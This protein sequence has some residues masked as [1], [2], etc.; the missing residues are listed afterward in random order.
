MSAG[1]ETG[2][3]IG[4]EY[5]MKDNSKLGTGIINMIFVLVL[6]IT[7]LF[8]PALTLKTQAGEGYHIYI[9][10]IA[11]VVTVY[12]DGE[13]V[14]AMITSTGTATPLSGT[15]N[16][17]N[18]F[19]W[20][21]LNGNVYGQYCTR[22]YK[23]ILFQSVPYTAYYNYGSLKHGQFDLLGTPASMGCMRLCVGDAKWI[24]DNIPAN[25]PV[26]FYSDEEVPSPMGMPFSC[27][28]DNFGES[29]SGWDPTDLNKDNPWN[30]FLGDAFDADYYLENN[31]DLQGMFPWTPVSLKLHWLTVGIAEGRCASK[32]FE[33]SAY[34]RVL[35]HRFGNNNYAYIAYYNLVGYNAPVDKITAEQRMAPY[36]KIDIDKVLGNGEDKEPEPTPTLKPAATATPTPV[37]KPTSAPEPTKVPVPTAVPAPKPSPTSV[38]APVVSPSM[39]DAVGYANRYPDLKEM[40][41]YDPIALWNHYDTIG[42]YEGRI[43]Y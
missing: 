15:Y 30:A 42:R 28:I 33:L 21:Y 6:T 29:F 9:N 13:P 34:K 1:A 25:T 14:R 20:G 35:D 16:T 8:Q 43:P 3:L 36:V 41:G 27:K 5:R 24:Y 26:T 19:D 12:Y 10:V 7:M 18:K 2:I 4:K 40:Y 23:G 39:F 17:S 31:P 37:P 32:I 11:N 22:I 38:P